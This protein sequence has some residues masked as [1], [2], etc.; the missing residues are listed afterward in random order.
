MD[1]SSVNASNRAD[2]YRKDGWKRFDP[3]APT[4]NADQVQR[5]RELY[6]VLAAASRTRTELPVWQLRFLLSHQSNSAVPASPALHQTRRRQRLGDDRTD[7]DAWRFRWLGRR[8]GYF[9]IQIVS[10]RA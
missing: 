10:Q 8:A 3:A 6:R 5:E 2:M 9:L 1:K 7:V 4:Y